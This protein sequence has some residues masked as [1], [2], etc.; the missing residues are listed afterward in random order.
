MDI[1]GQFASLANYIPRLLTFKQG[2]KLVIRHVQTVSTANLLRAVSRATTARQLTI[3]V[4]NLQEQIWKVSDVQATGRLHLADQLIDVLHTQ[5]LFAPSASVRTT[6]ASFLRMLIQMGLSSQP[7]TIFTT[8]VTA[9]VEASNVIVQGEEERFIYLKLLFECFWPFR[10]PNPAFSWE[11]FPSNS[12]F[13]PLAPQLDSLAQREQE[14][15][16]SIFSEL[17]RLDEKEFSDYLLPFALHRAQHHDARCRQSICGILARISNEQ[18]YEA[19]CNLKN[20][21]DAM[22]RARATNELHY[23]KQS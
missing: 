2:V 18:A 14:M 6:A 23:V 5:V 4:N 1:M 7:D 9:I 11:Q 8:L 17:P 19:L 22:V 10:Y 21:S 20:D 13:Y 3:A 12:I 16:L 15:L